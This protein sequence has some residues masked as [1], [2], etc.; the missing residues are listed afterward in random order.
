MQLNLSVKTLLLLLSLSFLLSCSQSDTPLKQYE[1]ALKGTFAAE[2]SQN[3]DYSIISTISHGIRLWDNRNNQLLYNWRHGDISDNA[4]YIVRISANNHYALSAST[5]EFAIWDI[6]TGHSVGFYKVTDSPIRDIQ[7]SE[8][9][10]YVLYGQVNGKLVH[11][12]LKTGRRLEMPIHTEKINSIDMSAN[13][14]Y[15]LSGG[16]DHRAFLWNTKTAQVI[17][18]FDFKNRVS[19]VRLE[20]TGRYAFISDTQKSA[21]IW[22]LKTGK[23]HSTLIFSARQSIFSSVRFIDN[24]KYL[25]TGNGTK[26][27]R[28]WNVDTGLMMQQ[29][30]VSAR[31]DTR[32][33]TAVVYSATLWDANNIASESSAGLLEIWPMN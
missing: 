30:M 32:P 28:L 23:L 20:P 7:I 9:G 6:K 14:L 3:G 10:R 4:I 27:L 29:W 18:K 11:I 25:L 31:K 12:D 2:I 16:N 26:M 19:T 33:K 5:H 21:Q 17:Q 1:H 24:G 22:D 15:A 13:G 8:N